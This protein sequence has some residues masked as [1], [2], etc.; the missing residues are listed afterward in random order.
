MEDV[1][2][3][4]NSDTVAAVVLQASSRAMLLQGSDKGNKEASVV[5]LYTS[6]SIGSKV[7]GQA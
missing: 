6:N 2:I 7:I 5:C 1:F 3:G 4:Y